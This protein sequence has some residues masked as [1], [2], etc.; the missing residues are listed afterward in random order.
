MKIVFGGAFNPITNA[1]ILVYKEVKKHFK[2][3]TFVF[4]PVSSAYTKSALASNHYRQEMLHLALDKYDD[5][6]ISDLEI[7][8]SDFLGTYQ[9]LI[10]ISDRYDE[11]VAFI[12]GSD[13]LDGMENWIN[14]EGLLSDFQIIV[15]NRHN[16]DIQQKINQSPILKKYQSKFYII[17]DFDVAISS[18]QF[19]ETFDQSLVPK[20]VYDY[21]KENDL[22]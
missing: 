18:T 4:L 11:E 13:N 14:I 3:A 6:E 2:H 10:R 1:H 5:I 16:D 21:I 9:S 8:D 12:V 19:R 17:N 15:L 7:N 20:E 22:Y